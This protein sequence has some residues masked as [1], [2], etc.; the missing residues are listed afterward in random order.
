MDKF[1]DFICK[2]KKNVIIVSLILL[3]LSF[4]GFKLTKVNYDILVYLPEDIE[5]I[6][7]QNILTN[8]FD[9]GSYSIAVVENMKSKDILKLEEKIKGVKGVEKVASLYD[10]VGTS[11]PLEML[12]SEV[13]SK[14]HKDNTDLLLITFSN[15]TSNEETLNAVEEIRNIGNNTLK[16]GGMSSM[17]LDTMNLSE[18]EVIIYVVIAVILCIV[19]LEIFLDSYIVPIL[20]LINIGVSI[21]FNL[22]TNVFLGSIS[23]ITKALVAVLQLGVTTDFSIFLYHSYEK[24]K[25][26][27]KTREIA[28]KEAIKETFSSVTGSSLTTIAGFL[29][30]CTME[31]TLGKDLGIVMAKG[32]LLGVICVLTLFPSLLLVFDKLIDKTKHKELTPNFNLLNKFIIK[33]KTLIFI[34]FIIL[35]IPIYLANSKV[36]VYY[37]LDKSLPSYLE[38]IETNEYLKDNYDIVSPEIILISSDLKNERKE[39]L[40][41]DLEKTKGINL[42]LS[43]EKLNELGIN[44]ELLSSDLISLVKNEKYE[45][46]LINSIYETATDELNEQI[47]EINDTIKKYDKEAI[48]AGEGPLMKDLVSISDKDFTNVNLSSIVCIFII[49]FFVLKSF[50]LPFLLIITIESA[51]FTNMSV[52]YFGGVTLPFIAPIVLGTIQLGA[53][54]DYAIL[55]TTTYLRYRKENISKEDAMMK[56]LNYNG[57]SILISGMCFFAATFGVGVYSK[58][59]MIGTLCALIARGAVISMLVV[60]VVLPSI[61]LIFDKLIMKTTLKGGEKMRKNIKRVGVFVIVLCLIL[62]PVNLF[63]LTKNETIYTKLNVDGSVKNTVINEQ[64]VNPL[65]LDELEDYSTLEDILNVGNDNTFKKNNNKIVWNASGKDV[66]YQGTTKKDLPISVNVTYKLD[67]KVMSIDDMIGKKGK[68]SITLKYKNN[69]SHKVYVNGKYENLFTPFVV[70]TATIIDSKNNTNISV[71]NGKV[72]SNGSKNIVISVLTPGLYES[73]GL[74]EIKDLDKMTISYDTE[75]FSLSSIMSLVTPKVIESSDL[76]LFSK[77]DSIYEK[78]NSLQSNMNKIDDA[79]KKVYSGSTEIKTGLYN[80]LNS[81]NTNEDALSKTQVD[82]IKKIATD[83]VNS[84]F[85]DNY[86]ENLKNEVDEIIDNS[87]SK[88]T[89][90]K[91]LSI[92]TNYLTS[93]NQS[94]KIPIYINCLENSSDST[95][96]SVQ[97]ELLL[98]KELGD[99]IKTTTKD[100]AENIATIFSKE[101]ALSTAETVVDSISVNVANLVDESVK[102]VSESLYTLYN[103]I[104]TLNQGISSLSS[105]ISKFNKE[106]ISSVS[107]LVNG[108]IKTTTSKVEELVNLSNQYNSFTTDATL[109]NSSTKFVF[110]ID[111][112]SKEEKINVKQ[113]KTN[114]TFWER[115]KNLFK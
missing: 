13:I 71:T 90:E 98:T 100:A 44:E 34:I 26:K 92:V 79:A 4:I 114:S 30:L 36:S 7:G 69:D 58:I 84:T 94:S 41:N 113:E 8:D 77:M 97:S 87:D 74:E 81:L 115:L 37:K 104:D 107:S 49:L 52:S 40:V 3:V 55:L 10:V 65:K 20:L 57:V 93:T 46:I 76:S 95:C 106:G 96:L 51:I 19:I 42:V 68:V 38:S 75:E 45:M 33:H 15:S 25:D 86:I 11:I 39:N 5:T 2:H 12:P 14:V 48:V 61:L 89:T 70:S 80:S 108:K 24:K 78:V 102:K 109:E 47:T 82:A 66:F 31:L 9:M 101:A 29:V 63:A 23:Y 105:G 67:G 111:G 110:V 27:S 53:T 1:A 83:T 112:K 60:I 62:S 16:Q 56:T 28:M 43:L 54:I 91:V 88:E 21:M 17:V 22:G 35:I 73:L 50:S 32:V 85:T 99:L 18:K 64:L 103:G 6:K 72:I 59:E